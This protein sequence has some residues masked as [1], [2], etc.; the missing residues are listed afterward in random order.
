[1]YDP[2]RRKKDADDEAD[3]QVGDANDNSEET[4]PEE[5]L[6]TEYIIGKDIKQKYKLPAIIK[7]RDPVPGEVNIWRRRA[8][9]KA[10]RIH[11]KL[12]M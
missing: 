10:A 11:K 6:L 9:P 7:I 8:F 12:N 1:M 3:E 2:F 5:N 4:F